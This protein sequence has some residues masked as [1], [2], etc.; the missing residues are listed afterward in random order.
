M[1]LNKTEAMN[2]QVLLL[3]EISTQLD[4]MTGLQKSTVE[5]LY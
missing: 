2:A 5:S 4:E 1:A 3:K